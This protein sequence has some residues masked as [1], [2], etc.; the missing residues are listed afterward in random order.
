MHGEARPGGPDLKS[1]TR[2]VAP[3]ARDASSGSASAERCGTSH[4]AHEA[5]RTLPAEEEAVHGEAWPGGPDLKG[6]TRSVAP[7]ARDASLGSACAELGVT[8]HRAHKAAR[9]LPAEE[10]AV[11][12][13]AWPG[14]PDLKRR[15][16]LRGTR[17]P[18]RPLGGRRRGALRDVA[19]GPRGRA[20][21]ASRRGSIH[22]AGV[23][24]VA[25]HI[26]G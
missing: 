8:S 25:L 2:S 10:E 12:G 18:R 9:T 13:E 23:R 24:G 17:S 1:V 7:G 26:G 14:G 19:A 21:V 22:H 4:R 11:H 6:V 15:D 20:H 3:G 5:A 16:Q